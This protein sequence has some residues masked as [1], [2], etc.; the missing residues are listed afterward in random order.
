MLIS[1]S[2]EVADGDWQHAGQFTCSEPIP[3]QLLALV[4]THPAAFAVER[5][6]SW[7]MIWNELIKQQRKSI[8]KW[9]AA[10]RRERLGLS[11]ALHWLMSLSAAICSHSPS[12]LYP[13]WLC[14]HFLGVRWEIWW[15]FV[16][17]LS[18]SRPFAPHVSVPVSLPAV[19]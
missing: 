12:D 14:W 16:L 6:K 18:R 5:K 2:G 15:L 17:Q 7:K 11:V 8:N 13:P 9:W 19:S 10:A 1:F 3:L 4:N